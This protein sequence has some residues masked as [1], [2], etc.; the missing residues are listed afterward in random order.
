MRKQTLFLAVAGT[1]LGVFAWQLSPLLRLAVSRM[2]SPEQNTATT[3][4]TSSQEFTED[5][6]KKESTPLPTTPS[7]SEKVVAKENDSAEKTFD[8]YAHFQ[9]GNYD[10]AVSQLRAAL[11]VSPQNELVRRNLGTALLALG[12]F[13]LQKKKLLKPKLRSMN[14][15]D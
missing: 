9:M 13:K 10:G 5:T 3:V 14:Q 4:D 7:L 15:H 12:F 8:A 11:K 6:L 2:T 1:A